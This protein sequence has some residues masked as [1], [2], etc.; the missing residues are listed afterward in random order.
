VAAGI[1]DTAP[2]L[3]E[4]RHAET[5]EQFFKATG[6]AIAFLASLF[7][8]LGTRY[9]GV[10][11]ENP[12]LAAQVIDHFLE[13]HPK[14]EVFDPLMFRYEEAPKWV[15]LLQ[16][17]LAPCRGIVQPDKATSLL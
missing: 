13:Q 8:A 6:D 4:L 16:N 11:E 12:I 9:L 15:G 2:D 5:R 14:Q 10:L 3:T 17:W 1:V 7:S